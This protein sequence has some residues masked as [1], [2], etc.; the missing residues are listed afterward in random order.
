MDKD[1]KISNRLKLATALRK[2]MDKNKEQVLQHEVTDKE[3]FWIV[4]S[5]R[6]LEATSGLSYTIVQG[7]F[8]A[9]RDIQFSSLM[10]MIGEGFGLTFSEFAEVYDSVTDEEVRAVKRNIAAMSK[11]TVKGKKK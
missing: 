4:N 2:I 6:Q 7:V 1:D 3:S 9:K 5:I 8:G 11:K 10:T